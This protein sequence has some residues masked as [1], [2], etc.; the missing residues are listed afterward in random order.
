MIQKKEDFDLNTY[1]HSCA[2]VMALAAKRLFEDVKLG[3]GPPIQDGFYY[4]FDCAHKLVP[5]DF[6]ALEEEM[7][8]IIKEDIP[9]VREE[10]SKDDAVTLFTDRNE[11]YK[12]RLIHELGDAP[13]S[14]YRN[15][16]FVDLCKGPHINSTG[17]IKAF[18]LLSVAGAYWHGNE[19]NEMM[20]RIYATM[21]NNPKELRE[22][23]RRRDEAKKRDHRKLGKELRLFMIHDE[24]GAGL[25]TFLPKGMRLRMILEDFEKKEHLKRGYEIVQGPSILK[26]DVWKKSGH[27]QMGY[28]MYFFDIDG[29]EYGLKPMNCP[30]HIYIYKSQLHSY[31]ELPIRYFELG[32]VHRHEKSGVLHGLLRVRSFTQDDA[33]IFCMPEQLLEEIKSVIDFVTETLVVFGFEKFQAE[34]STR[35]EKSIGG[36][37]DWARSTHVLKSALDE[38]KIKY[39]VKEG[40]GAFYGPKIDIKLTDAIGREWQCATIQ[41]DFSLPERFGLEYVAKDGSRKRPVMLHR[42]ILGSIE[43]FMGVLI[44][45]YAGKFPVW[46]S[47]EQTRVLTIG[48]GQIDYAKKIKAD[49]EGHDIRSG[50]D[51]R[52]EKIGL[53][54]RQTQ[55]DKVPYMIIVG[56]REEENKT[57]SLRERD[58]KDSCSVSIE[59]FIL[60]INEE[61]RTRKN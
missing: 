28:P 45:H 55:L 32:T 41:C 17:Q 1:R 42:V 44:E 38:K 27:Y 13:L 54:I 24:M 53:K 4:D 59:D 30:G 20:Q 18:K 29:T 43:R 56:A 10:I 31:R 34:L 3:I 22:Y 6:P 40:D 39:E 15:G 52:D 16:D 50:L 49:L 37:E 33:H 51:I 48:A 9:F 57:I 60:K 61:I 23:L 8:K 35:P 58:K 25:I 11:T 26:S 36:D 46:L 47:P 21:F 19:A 12:L 14:V 2:H 5:E 7:K